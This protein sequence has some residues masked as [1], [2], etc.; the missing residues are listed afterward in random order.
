MC[1]FPFFSHTPLIKGWVR[2]LTI[3][4]LIM[5]IR[6]HQREEKVKDEEGFAGGHFAY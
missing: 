2:I 1:L 5:T 3:I 4:D 6:V